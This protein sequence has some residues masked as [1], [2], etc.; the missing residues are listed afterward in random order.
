[1]LVGRVSIQIC[2]TPRA[3][4]TAHF[5]RNKMHAQNSGSLGVEYR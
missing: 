1:L 5:D 3:L 2:S 4:P